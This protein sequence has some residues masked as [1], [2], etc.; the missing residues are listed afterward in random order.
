MGQQRLATH[1]TSVVAWLSLQPKRYLNKSFVFSSYFKSSYQVWRLLR[2]IGIG[3]IHH[4]QIDTTILL[5]NSPNLYCPWEQ[6]SV[7]NSICFIVVWQLILPCFL[8]IWLADCR[9]G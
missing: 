5:W 8:T 7:K 1:L 2:T 4:N 9:A 6:V 3:H